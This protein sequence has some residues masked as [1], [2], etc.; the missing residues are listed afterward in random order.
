MALAISV[1]MFL[2][3]EGTV[4]ELLFVLIVWDALS[5]EAMKGERGENR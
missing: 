1:A 5:I 4:R 2:F 3:T